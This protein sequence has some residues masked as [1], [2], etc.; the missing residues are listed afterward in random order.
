MVLLADS[1]E[2]GICLVRTHC[3]GLSYGSESEQYCQCFFTGFGTIARSTQIVVMLLLMPL[4]CNDLKL[5]MVSCP[6]CASLRQT[7]MGEQDS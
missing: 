5:V 6:L 4:S 2:G 7:F 3:H 1:Y